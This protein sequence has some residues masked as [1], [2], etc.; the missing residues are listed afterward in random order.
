MKLLLSFLFTRRRALVVAAILPMVWIG[1]A[2]G[3]DCKRV[4]NILI[5]FDASG[6]MKENNRYALLMKTMREFEKAI[7]LTAD[8]FFNV[9]LRH[10]GLRVGMGCRNTESVLSVQ[11]WD[12]ERFLNS[13][14]K[15]VSYGVSSLSTGLRAA[16]DEVTSMDGKSIVVVIGGG[17]ESCKSD[18]IKIAEQIAY[19]YPE[20]E[21]HTFQI[22]NAQEGTF[23]LESIADKAR[24][25]FTRVRELGDSAG[26]HQWMKKVLVVPC[27]VPGTAQAPPPGVLPPPVQQPAAVPTP[28]IPELGPVYF[29]YNS[30]T[31]RSKDPNIDAANMNNL[32]EAAAFL[33]ANP[34]CRLV[35]HGYTDGKGSAE[36]NL[37]LSKRRADAVSRFLS[38][39]FQ[40][41]AERMAVI[42]HGKAQST[43][44]KRR[45]SSL[46]SGRRVEFE[47]FF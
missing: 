7:P 25:T 29:D 31:P 20:L 6:Y 19:N 35:I 14:P 15:T 23:F 9:G 16:A 47:V 2:F 33:R 13:F 4:E 37:K 10:Y 24:G 42:P 36:Y 46:K 28:S 39:Q 30:F 18:P 17:L 32:K 8:G 21:I 27:T 45:S 22:G 5:L 11:P 12:P 1:A 43:I 3:D 40:V 38:T 26:W 34:S 41:P 44:L